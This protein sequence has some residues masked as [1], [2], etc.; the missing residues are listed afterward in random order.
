MFEIVNL[1]IRCHQ[2]LGYCSLLV[3]TFWYSK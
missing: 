1:K 3:D 2:N